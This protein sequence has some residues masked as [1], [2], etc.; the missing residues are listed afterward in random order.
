MLGEE[1]WR[2][3]GA[4]LIELSKAGFAD[5]LETIGAWDNF[6]LDPGKQANEWQRD[7]F[8]RALP[9]SRLR[10]NGSADLIEDVSATSAA[11]APGKVLDHTESSLSRALNLADRTASVNLARVLQLCV[12]ESEL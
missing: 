7:M 2:M 8:W 12:A 11:G 5:A 6:G 10:K 4:A 9:P 3:A 1:L